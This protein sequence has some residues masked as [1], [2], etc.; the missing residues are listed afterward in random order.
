MGKQKDKRKR[1]AG[2]LADLQ[3]RARWQDEFEHAMLFF[4]AHPDEQLAGKTKLPYKYFYRKR[5][6]GI[7]I[8]PYI[9]E[10]LSYV[11]RAG[12]GNKKKEQ[13]YFMKSKYKVNLR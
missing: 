1:K 9:V 4:K 7:N 8:D 12:T 3:E 13:R 11:R 6:E 10:T 2:L 5:A